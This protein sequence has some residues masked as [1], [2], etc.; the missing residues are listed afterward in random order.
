MHLAVRLIQDHKNEKLDEVLNASHTEVYG[1]Y[2]KKNTLLHY[3]AQ[4]NN[5]EAVKILHKLNV[6][7]DASNKIGLTPLHMAI[8]FENYEIASFLIKNGANVAA[9]TEK[10]FTPLHYAYNQNHVELIKQLIKNGASI[11]A[12]SADGTIALSMTQEKDVLEIIKDFQDILSQNVNTFTTAEEARINLQ[13]VGMIEPDPSFTEK[14]SQIKT[15]KIYKYHDTS[16]KGLNVL[17]KVDVLPNLRPEYKESIVDQINDLK[18]LSQPQSLYYFGVT[19]MDSKR[20]GFMAELPVGRPTLEQLV[21]HNDDSLTPLLIIGVMSS[22]LKA[23]SFYYDR[24]INIYRNFIVTPSNVF[25]DIVNRSAVTLIEPSLRIDAYNVFR[26][27]PEFCAPEQLVDPKHRDTLRNSLSYTWGAIFYYVICRGLKME[28]Q[29]KFDRAK[30]IIKCMRQNTL[31]HDV[32]IL[33]NPFVVRMFKMLLTTSMQDRKPISAIVVSNLM[34]GLKT[35]VEADESYLNLKF[36]SI[37]PNKMRADVNSMIRKSTISVETNDAESENLSEG[38]VDTVAE[39]SDEEEDDS[40]SDHN[41][42]EDQDDNSESDDKE[43][44]ID[45]PKAD[46]NSMIRESTVTVETNSGEEEDD[47]ENDRN[48]E[49]D[50][51]DNDESDDKKSSESDELDG[52]ESL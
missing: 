16:F 19:M 13:N 43:S 39:E 18:L 40:E 33:E 21:V 49:K 5:L 23:F 10:G 2:V 46:V 11:Y 41:E 42:K 28:E 6:N 26:E 15:S 36:R 29:Y 17:Y 34:M 3:A 35:E 52:S 14:I 45:D 32:E 25:V 24:I 51:D 4:Y 1:S 7:I 47:S 20:I 31:V 50:K 9:K 37:V 38:V 22:I 27:D 48:E 44:A 12:K 30:K 8:I